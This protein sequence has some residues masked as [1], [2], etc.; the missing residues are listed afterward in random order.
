MNPRFHCLV[1]GLVTLTACSDSSS[2]PSTGTADALSQAACDSLSMEA[3]SVMSV[4]GKDEAI[5][6]A[7][8]QADAPN[9]IALAG[10]IS[11]VALE[12]PTPHTD[13]GI[14]VKPAGSVTATSTTTLTEEHLD[15]SCPDEALG[16]LRLHIHEFEHSILTLEGEGQVWLYFGAAG[17][18]GHGGEGG[19][20]GHLGT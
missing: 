4:L 12:V 6:N 20:G 16:D 19:H 1:L 7:L 17:E 2:G 3:T 9:L 18:S 14:F 10:P 15:A 13:Y 11:Y 5:A 8:I